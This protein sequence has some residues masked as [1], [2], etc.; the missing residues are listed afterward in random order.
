MMFGNLGADRIR[1]YF[2]LPGT[3][4]AVWRERALQGVL[5][6]TLLTASFAYVTNIIDSLQL[7]NYLWIAITSVAYLWLAVI[8]LVPGLPYKFRANSSVFLLYLLGISALL[9]EGLPSN[10]RG[11]LIATTIIA[12]LFLSTRAG[13]LS[14][15]SN[16]VL[17]LV[18]ALLIGLDVV[19]P[20]VPATLETWISAAL[21]LIMHNTITAAPTLALVSRLQENLEEAQVL[22]AELEEERG[23]LERR[24]GERTRALATSL[25][26][27][28][29][30]STI[31]DQ[32]RLVGEVVNQL[33]RGFGY[34]HV[35]IYLVDEERRAL[36]LAGGTGQPAQLML[37]RGHYLE[38][39]EGLVGRAAETNLPVLVRDVSREPGWLPNTLLPETKS[40]AAI[41][42]SR[43][44]DVLGVLDVQEDVVDG[45]S[46]EEVEL[47]QSIANQTAVALQN[48]Q[49]FQRTQREAEQEAIAGSITQEI[50]RATTVEQALQVAARELG[51]VLDAP[52]TRVRLA[53]TTPPTNGDGHREPAAE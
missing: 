53:A 25:E 17:I 22:S 8:A 4:L 49:L 39:G 33:Q 18:I 13:I 50:Q 29:R 36:V 1:S 7:G 35:H 14:L 31:L 9:T 42:V 27:S 23:L 19:N 10:G 44:D 16:I 21:T 48:A 24:V 37:K 20:I 30:L 6:V 41:P 43:G 46:R 3:D 2:D 15:L 5:I 40:E 51:R 38:W 12:G 52:E 32:E 28:R 34:Y 45:L 47:L 26:I 11:Y